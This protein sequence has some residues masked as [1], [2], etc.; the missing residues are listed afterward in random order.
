MGSLNFVLFS[1]QQILNR[2]PT[3]VEQ[4]S[5]VSM[6]DGSSAVL[7]LQSGSS[8]DDYLSIFFNA[9][10]CYEGA[11]VRLYHDFLFRAPESL[12]MSVA[13][14]QYKN[15]GDYEQLQ[16]DILATDEFVGIN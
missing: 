15:T 8:K 11:V 16:K 4:N 2:N 5:G 14:I 12:E 13:A 7:F 9:D 10:D 1:F 6:I 3:L